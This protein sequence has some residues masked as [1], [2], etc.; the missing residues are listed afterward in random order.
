MTK[1]AMVLEKQAAGGFAA[2]RIYQNHA[3]VLA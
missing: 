2:V 3:H 1:G